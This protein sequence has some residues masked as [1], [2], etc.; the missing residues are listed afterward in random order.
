MRENSRKKIFFKGNLTKVFSPDV[1]LKN[2][3]KVAFNEELSMYNGLISSLLPSFNSNPKLLSNLNSDFIET[4]ATSV[5]N[6]LLPEG[7]FSEDEK[8]L[9]KLSMIQG[10]IPKNTRKIMAK[11]ILKFFSDQAKSKINN[12]IKGSLSEKMEYKNAIQTLSTLDNLTKRHIQLLKSDTRWLYDEKDNKTML[13]I[14]YSRSPIILE[15]FN[16]ND[17]KGWN[18]IVIHQK[19]G[20]IPVSS[21][22]WL[23][24]FK[25][26]ITGEY[27][28]KYVDMMGNKSSI[29]K[30]N[31]FR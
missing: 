16:L 29:N 31:S 24:E 3:L 13:Y 22:P 27:L 17:L 28:I 21:T 18:Y 12:K 10:N 26:N 11:T 30:V 25:E 5:S 20:R 19:P 23:I 6:R 4:F 1:S 15:N 14:P 7:N 9:L 2:S 8:I